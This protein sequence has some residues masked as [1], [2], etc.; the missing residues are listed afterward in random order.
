[1]AEDLEE[2]GIS[3]SVP[4]DQGSQVS[5]IIR[6]VVID[7]D[8]E[9]PEDQKQAGEEE[10]IQQEEEVEEE[11][12]ILFCS[13]IRLFFFFLNIHLYLLQFSASVQGRR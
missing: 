4:S 2:E 7:T 1:M 6:D 12:V 13:L 10:E 8:S 3:Q 5:T 11:E 9:S